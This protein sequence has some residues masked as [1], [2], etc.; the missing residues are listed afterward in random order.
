MSYEKLK[1]ENYVKLLGI[2]SKNSTYAT[3]EGALLNLVNMDFSI[4]GSYNRRPGWTGG[5]AG[6]TFVMSSP[7]NQIIQLSASYVDQT[8]SHIKTLALAE[9]G[10]ATYSW[11]LGQ[12][13][14]FSTVTV[15]RLTGGTQS[16]NQ[17]VSTNMFSFG[18]FAS[19]NT[20]M[21]FFDPPPGSGPTF[22]YFGQ[23]APGTFLG[24]PAG[25]TISNAGSAT[26]PA[27]T[28]NYYLGWFDYNNWDPTDYGIMTQAFA[29]PLSGP[30]AVSLGTGLHTVTFYNLT[31]TASDALYGPVGR[32]LYRDNVSGFDASDIVALNYDLTPANTTIS[33]DNANRVVSST[34]DPFIYGETPSLLFGAIALE[35]FAN[36]LFA[37][38]YTTYRGANSVLISTPLNPQNLV[39]KILLA[40]GNFPLMGLRTFENSL[41]IG[42]T[43]GIFRLT[44]TDIENFLV[45]TITTEYGFVSPKAIVTWKN[46]CWFL[47]VRGIVEYNGSSFNIVSDRIEPLIKRINLTS[48]LQKAQAYYFKNRNEVWFSV[49]IDGA[50]YNNAVLV[51]DIIM[52]QWTTFVGFQATALTTLFKG[53]NLYNFSITSGMYFGDVSG[54]MN[55]FSTSLLGDN[56][57]GFTCLMQTRFLND[58]G[59]STE[60]QFRRLFLDSGPVPG[61]TQLI[62]IEMYADHATSL[63]SAT[64]S[65]YQGVYQSRIDF[66]VPA[67][68][69]SYLITHYSSAEPFQINGYTSESRL[70]RKV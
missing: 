67:K 22:A 23:Q 12:Y 51:Y 56:G 29:G 33:D 27:G 5:M 62:N 18:A 1:N 9:R 36:T 34:G 69:I 2:N 37:V 50:T 68:A 28:V 14:N 3:P 54:S 47:D 57:S 61:S 58:L 45:D 59:N 52:D 26:F 42:A 63:V 41:L 64:A 24:I 16:V 43:Q 20:A 15:N 38:P 70:Q 25:V 8:N 17:W 4:P 6:N 19:E 11:T 30:F 44:G 35:V 60:K 39:D 66:G 32:V 65:M 7:I 48:A 53:S 21:K 40:N 46:V 49:P 10:F 31:V 13:S 55:Y